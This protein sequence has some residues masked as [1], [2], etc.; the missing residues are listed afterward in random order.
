MN[1][2]PDSS[3]PDRA[4]AQYSGPWARSRRLQR[5]ATPAS[6]R[7]AARPSPTPQQR[8]A[9][10]RAVSIGVPSF[11]R[12]LGTRYE[13]QAPIGYGGAA[14]VFLSYDRRLKC[15]TALKIFRRVDGSHAQ[16]R[17]R[18]RVEREARALASLTSPYVVTLYGVGES[19]EHLFLS[20]EYVEGCTLRQWLRDCWRPWQDILN[21]FLQAGQALA[22]AHTRGLVHCDF[23]PVNL[24]VDRDGCARLIDFGQVTPA[25]SVF[26][27]ELDSL[28][29]ANASDALLEQLEEVGQPLGTLE[30]MAPEQYLRQPLTHATDQFSFCVALHEA[31]Y[32]LRPFAGSGVWE[33]GLSVTRGQLRRVSRAE[34]DGPGWLYE[35]VLRGLRREQTERFPAMLALLETLNS[36]LARCKPA[37]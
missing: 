20:T 17:L 1:G 19:E 13:I 25:G 2:R 37:E 12:S 34:Q 3:R 29:G 31:L 6:P 23:N 36:G 15:K 18:D 22:A 35:A 33:L 28:S 30:Y 11:V 14:V 16:A 8:T 21:I 9:S 5:S 27:E 26:D 10:S 24:L 4:G 7:P 32:G